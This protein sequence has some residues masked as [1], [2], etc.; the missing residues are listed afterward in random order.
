MV[1]VVHTSSN[2][3]RYTRL[4]LFFHNQSG[5]DFIYTPFGA[6][7]RSCIGGLFSLLTV[8]TIVASCVQKFDFSPDEKSLPKDAPIPLRYDVTMCY[9]NGL[10]MKVKRRDVDGKTLKTVDRQPAAS[11]R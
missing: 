1:T 6:G 2:T 4:T 7:P 8:T 3:S 11:A 10:K 9:P 5:R